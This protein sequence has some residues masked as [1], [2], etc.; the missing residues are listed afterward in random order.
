MKVSQTLKY[1]LLKLCYCCKR[2][3]RT[4]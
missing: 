4:N 2:E 3:S 1:V